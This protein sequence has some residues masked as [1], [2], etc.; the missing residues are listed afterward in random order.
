MILCKESQTR[1]KVGRLF[2]TRFSAIGSFDIEKFPI[3]NY[4]VFNSDIEGTIDEARRRIHQAR[5]LLRSHGIEPAFMIDEEGGR[6]SNLWSPF[7]PAPSPLAISRVGDQTL[8]V[9]IYSYA[10]TLLSTIRIEFNLF[11]CLDVLS[12]PMNPVIATRSFGESVEPVCTFGRL[13]LFAMQDSVACIAK[14]FPGH[15]M[16]SLDSHLELPVVNLDK[17]SLEHVHIRP[18]IEAIANRVDGIMVSHCYYES[19]QSEEVP[20]SL[21]KEIIKQYLRNQIGF[22]G[23][24]MSDSLD[25]KAVTTRIEPEMVAKLAIEADCDILL[26]TEFSDRLEKAFDTLVADLMQGNVSL[27]RVEKS[28]QRR[29][30][31]LGRLLQPKRPLSNEFFDEDYQAYYET[32]VQE[33]RSKVILK[34]DP[35]RILPISRDDITLVIG[36]R[37]LPKDLFDKKLLKESREDSKGKIPVLWM[38]DPLKPIDDLSRLR[39]VT[40]SAKKSVLVTSY[41]RMIEILEPTATVLTLDTARQAQEEVLRLILR[42]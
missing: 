12:E 25:M 1:S 14:H 30:S 19:L 39:E 17:R 9:Q 18:F 4:I 26:F 16:T 23:L 31:V 13:A 35:H 27:Q 42:G 21:S 34:K 32:I 22:D 36:T 7:Q 24:V 8:A 15:G 10:A 40:R 37:D 5:M 41:E 28:I 29:E 6:V 20:A 38:L 33:I 3:A 2:A 11:P